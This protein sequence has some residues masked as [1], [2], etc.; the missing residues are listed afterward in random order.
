M[1]EI[2]VASEV[3]D[4]LHHKQVARD[5]RP[6]PSPTYAWYVVAVFVIAYTFSFIDRQ[7]LS[8][9]VGPM[10]R[11]LHITDTEMSLLQGLAFAAFYTIMGLP[12]GRLVDRRNRIGI[13]SLGVFFWSLMTALCGTAKVYWQLFAYRIGVGVG[14][15][16]LSPAAYS[17]ISDYFPPKRLGI[18]IGV[19]GMGVYIGA[20]LALVIGAEVIGFVARSGD[21]NLPLL[22]HLYAWQIVFF[23]VGLPG[24]LI[25]LWVR[26]VREP[27]RRGHMRREIGPDG[28]ERDSEVPLADVIAYLKDNAGSFLGMNLC[29]AFLAMM[30]YGTAAWIP[31]FLVR[32]YGWDVVE[33]GR[34]YGWIIVIFGT[35]GVVAGGAIG[36]FV[37][38]KGYRNGRIIVMAATGLVTL[39]FAIAFPLVDD[40]MM[41]LA[42]LA[43]ASFFATFTTGVGP[44]ALQEMMPNQMRGF[45]A[46]LSG[47]IVNFIGLGLGPTSIALVTDFVFKDE[48]M[49]RY[50]LAA[51]PPV[52]LL[53]GAAFGFYSLK[54][55]LKSLDYLERWS[56]RN[57]KS[58]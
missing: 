54:P 29:F 33:A 55:Y 40:P 12:I 23:I 7:I 52:I 5:A 37:C 10:K 31:T 4:V 58:L 20:G 24:L 34:W 8:L 44:S 1:A 27:E 9:L 51:V 6:Y 18:A 11:D 32:T 50:S 21:L 25:A 26:T 2:E 38:S 56:S 22:G 13:I 15:A 46:A 49:L 45:A 14:E 19:Y 36:D 57:E 43:P 39:P 35:A 16:A 53:I 41:A 47:L 17:V 42:L 48:M 30:A 28:V 3:E